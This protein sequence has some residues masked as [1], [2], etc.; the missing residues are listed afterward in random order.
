MILSPD[1]S[2]VQQMLVVALVQAQSLELVGQFR[3]RGDLNVRGLPVGQEQVPHCTVA[4]ISLG[5]PYLWPS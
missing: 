1:T 5:G 3:F 2:G 4:L